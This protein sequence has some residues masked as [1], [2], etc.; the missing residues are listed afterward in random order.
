METGIFPCSEGWSRVNHLGA[1]G[2][3]APWLPLA[4][5]QMPNSTGG[6]RAWPGAG[7]RFCRAL[8]EWVT[9]AGFV[10][11]LP[12]EVIAQPLQGLVLKISWG[13]SCR[14]DVWAG[15]W[16]PAVTFSRAESLVPV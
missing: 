4:L 7:S 13:L 11:W 6:C 10:P 1:P 16:G 9:L 5:L 14:W 8:G 2:A 15:T 12:Q 3:A